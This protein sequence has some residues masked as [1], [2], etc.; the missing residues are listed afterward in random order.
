M[1]MV[2]VSVGDPRHFG[3]STNG[4]GW[5]KNMQILRIRIPNTCFE[6]ILDE[7]RQLCLVRRLIIIRV[8]PAELRFGAETFILLQR[9]RQLEDLRAYA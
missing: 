6:E 2:L 3:A 5:L 4:S 1:I 7:L 8:Y 9:L